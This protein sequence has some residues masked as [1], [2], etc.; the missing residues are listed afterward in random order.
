MRPVATVSTA[1]SDHIR[2]ALNPI[3]VA[4]RGVIAFR[5]SRA[6]Q[7]F[8]SGHIL[9]AVDRHRRAG[10]TTRLI[11]SEEHHGTRDFLRLT[12]TIDRDQRQDAFLEHVLWHR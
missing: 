11:R 10:D 9:P 12:E 8:P 1:S 2:I 6:T 7:I 5:F 4:T 3:S